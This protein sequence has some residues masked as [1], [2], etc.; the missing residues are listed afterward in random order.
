LEPNLYLQESRLTTA[1]RLRV[2]ILVV[3]LV[4]LALDGLT[5][6]LA[7]RVLTEGAEPIPSP[8]PFI[9]WYLSYN[10]GYHYILGNLASFR[11]VFGLAMVLAIAMLV[12]LLV[13]LGRPSGSHAQRG[14]LIAVTT[15]LVGALGNP[16]EVVATGHATDFFRVSG[17]PWT[18]NLC[19]Q[20]VN[21][22][23]YVLMPILLVVTLVE[24]RRVRR[25][26]NATAAAA[27]ST[28]P[29]EG[30]PLQFP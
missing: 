19:D 24:D 16:I 6:F 23:V 4:F 28:N 25:D 18:A 26:Q 27:P 20:Y 17:F 15:L 30:N 2:R 8:F 5:K 11:L 29:G 1:W 21:L 9:R 22:I 10:S 12:Y 13:S 14:L 7:V 3:G